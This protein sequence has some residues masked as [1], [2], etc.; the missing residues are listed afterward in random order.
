M[1][2]RGST[3]TDRRYGTLKRALWQQCKVHSLGLESY[4]TLKLQKMIDYTY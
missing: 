2:W 3:N 4:L 1:V